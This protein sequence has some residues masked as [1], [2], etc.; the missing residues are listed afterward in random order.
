MKALYE[1]NLLFC[2]NTFFIYFFRVGE[3]SGGQMFCSWL[4]SSLQICTGALL[5]WWEQ[6]LEYILHF[7][8]TLSFVVGIVLY[9]WWL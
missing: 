4:I 3:Y 5:I 2:A 8:Y 7:S 6:L 1:N 9:A